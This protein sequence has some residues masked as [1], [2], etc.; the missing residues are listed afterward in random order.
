MKKLP[1]LACLAVVF[2]VSAV[3]AGI[4]AQDAVRFGRIDPAKFTPE[5]KKFAA[6]LSQPPRNSDPNGGPFKVYL[7]SPEFGTRAIAMSDYLRWGTELG[8]RLTEFTILIAARQWSSHYVW[9]AHYPAAIKGGLDPSVAAD[10]AAGKRPRAMKADEAI[11]YNLVTEIYRDRDV[12]DAT[13]SAA[14]AKFGEKGV[15]D[16]VGLAGYYGITSMSLIAVRTPT[17]PGDEPKL[18]ALAQPFPK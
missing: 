1:T 14:V 6:M 15:T 13:F 7:R 10:V 12:S 11:V 17:A 18:Q 9:H 8:P 2:A 5:Q 3:P 16:I 4:V